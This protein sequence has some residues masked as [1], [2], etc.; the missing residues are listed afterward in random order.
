MAPVLIPRH[1]GARVIVP[2]IVIGTGSCSIGL[3]GF[4]VCA[5]A[6]SR[7]VATVEVNAVVSPSSCG[8]G[9]KRWGNRVLASLSA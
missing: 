8:S 1:P 9:S 3:G 4:S 5:A 2:V 6:S 7:A